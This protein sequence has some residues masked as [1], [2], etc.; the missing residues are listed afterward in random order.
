M[1]NK[2]WLNIE[3]IIRNAVMFRG[4]DQL[5]CY[6]ILISSCKSWLFYS[7]RLCEYLSFESICFW[8]EYRTFLSCLALSGNTVCCRRS[9]YKHLLP[10]TTIPKIFPVYRRTGQMV[11]FI[12]DFQFDMEWPVRCLV[13]LNIF[14]D[15]KSS[16]AF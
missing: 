10:F 12:K 11:I 14:L 5:L 15:K 7:E 3:K 1:K 8:A 4:K 16:D 9:V 2:C 6:F 13:A